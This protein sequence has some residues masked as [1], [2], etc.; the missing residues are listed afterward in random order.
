MEVEALNGEPG[1]KSARY[2]G[3]PVSHKSNIG[4]LLKNMEGRPNRRARFRTIISLRWQGGLFHFEGVCPGKI[5]TI[6]SGANGFGYD[7]IFMPE[8]ATKSFGEMGLNEKSAYSHRAKAVE[9]LLAF[10]ET[11]Q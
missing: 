10:L 7:P 11:A 1:V 2:A 8:G 6:E 4:L 9:K 5:Q 3:E